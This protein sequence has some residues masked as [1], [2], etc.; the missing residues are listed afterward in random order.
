[1]SVA[2]INFPPHRLGS[3]DEFSN[4]AEERYIK[5]FGAL[6]QVVAVGNHTII[7]LDAPG[8]VEEDLQR[9]ASGVSF[10]QWAATHPGGPI[11]FV[12]HL[13]AGQYSVLS[14]L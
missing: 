9:V 10:D 4:H 7:L 12:E 14:G 11:G 8:L 3:V 1:M 6:D 5:H 13:E 2:Q